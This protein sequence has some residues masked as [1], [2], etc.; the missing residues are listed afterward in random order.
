MYTSQLQ[1][2]T[3]ELTDLIIGQYH[4]LFS[5]YQD[6]DIAIHACA[7]TRKKKPICFRSVSCIIHFGCFSLFGNL[8]S[9]IFFSP[10][11][12]GKFIKSS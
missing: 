1:Y 6:I 4:N 8:F 10:P 9:M 3:H 11:V 5:T 12:Q 7:V 2:T